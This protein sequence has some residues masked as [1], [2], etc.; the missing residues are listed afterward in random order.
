VDLFSALVPIEIVAPLDRCGD[1]MAELNRIGGLVEHFD[2][3]DPCLVSAK[4]PA[5]ALKDIEIWV[6][7]TFAD[8]GKVELRQLGP[9]SASEAGMN[10]QSS[11][12]SVRLLQCLLAT[13]R[14]TVEKFVA[15]NL[16]GASLWIGGSV[17]TDREI[18][19]LR[20]RGYSVTVFAHRLDTDEDIADAKET[21]SEHHPHE[22]LWV[23]EFPV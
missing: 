3:S 2:P 15:E 1:V 20:E 18:I 6:G 14:E 9:L 4:I 12:G 13:R 16:T 7:K 22:R 19:G 10:E 5:A 21:I 17:L 23:D 8:R 11:V